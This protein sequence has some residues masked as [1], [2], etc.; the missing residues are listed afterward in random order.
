MYKHLD[1]CYAFGTYG[2]PSLPP[3]DAVVLPSVIV[4]NLVINALKQ[5]D[6]YNVRI[7]IHGGHQEQGREHEESYA[8]TILA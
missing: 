4:L 2:C 7:C 6:N 1:S 3:R 5:I 8:H